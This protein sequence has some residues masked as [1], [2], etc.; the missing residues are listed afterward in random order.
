MTK[1]VLLAAGK[2]TRTTSMKQ[3]YKIDGEYLIN[4]QIQKLL[5]YGFEVVVVL[6]HNY[7]NILSI[8]DKRVEVVFN[9]NYEDGMFSSV[10]EAF[11]KLNVDRF[12]FYHVDRPMADKTVS[13]KLLA[14]DYHVGVAYCCGKKAPPILIDFSMKKRL[15]SAKENRL[16][17]WIESLTEVDY[18][19]VSDEKIHL[20]ANSDKELKKYF[21]G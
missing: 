6:G 9:K 18:V 14:T 7:E 5:A 16:D 12:L 19:A 11:K 21:K 1:I 4:T 3:L 17:Y 10:K 20:N 13:E 2:S 15:L 8:L